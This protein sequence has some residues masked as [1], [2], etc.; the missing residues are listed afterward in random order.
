MGGAS[1]LRWF[2]CIDWLVLN[3]ITEPLTASSCGN[4]TARVEVAYMQ[5]NTAF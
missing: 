2:A 3:K 5:K 1:E 4:K